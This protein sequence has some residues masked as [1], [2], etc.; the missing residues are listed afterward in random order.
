[1][2]IADVP[3]SASGPWPAP[4][5]L[6]LLLHITGRRADGYHELQTLFQFLTFGDWLYFDLRMDGEVRLAGEPAG[7]PAAA[8]LC[9]RA[10]RLLKEATGS[11]AGVTIYNDKRLPSGGGLGGGSSDAATTLAVLNKL[12]KPGL[13]RDELAELGLSLGADVPVFVHGEAAWAEGVGE[14][15]IPVTLPE[16]WFL[17]VNPLVSVSTANIFSDPG[18]TRDTPRTKIPDPLTGVG[19]NDCEAVVRRRYPEVAAAL[20]WLNAF[21]PARMTGTGGCVFAAFDSEAAASVVAG[22][23]PASWSS[24]F[25]RGVNLSPLR[26]AL[27]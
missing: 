16:P 25:A 19:K 24:F 18:L 3:A 27:V 7:V 5:K 20:D 10:A 23:V 13:S 26:Q 6:N 11:N 15:L 9:V 8:D 17:V 2:K 14:V 4:A 22:Q 21:A 1:M 12:W